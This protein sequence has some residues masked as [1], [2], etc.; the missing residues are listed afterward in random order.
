MST[1]KRQAKA[2]ME[3]SA[4]RSELAGG[5]AAEVAGLKR[6]GR[7]NYAIV[8][9]L[10]LSVVLASLAA[11]AWGLFAE[12]A[13]WAIGV[14]ALIPAAA[15]LLAQELK[16]QEKANYYY[17]WAQRLDSIRSRAR[18]SS[19]PNDNVGN[20][21]FQAGE[22]RERMNEEWESGLQFG[23]QAKPTRP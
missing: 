17:R 23:W 16:L 22:L 8:F 5:L 11:G 6:S 3:L 14:V 4:D 18:F 2:Q 7:R 15:T 19:E 1:V 10:K 20:L 13:K 9:M 12:V 21:A